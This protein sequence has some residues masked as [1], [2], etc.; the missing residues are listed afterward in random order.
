VLKVSASFCLVFAIIGSLIAGCPPGEPEAKEAKDG[1]IAV[2]DFT[3]GT[4]L[5]CISNESTKTKNYNNA[6]TDFANKKCTT[7]ACSPCDVTEVDN[8]LSLAY[9]HLYEAESYKN[10]AKSNLTTASSKK[11]SAIEAY[12]NSLWQTCVTE[13]DN[14]KSYSG[15]ALGEVYDANSVL[16]QVQ[17]YID[18]ANA[19]LAKY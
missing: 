13:S 4:Y 5:T 6:N 16:G 7:M 19:I 12:N 9:S 14:S 11:T 17:D 8:L 2:Y 18:Q 15:E 1:A 3:Y 10:Q